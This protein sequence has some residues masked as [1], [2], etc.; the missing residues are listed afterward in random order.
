MMNCLTRLSIAT[1]TIATYALLSTAPASA[2]IALTETRQTVP[3]PTSTSVASLNQDVTCIPDSAISADNLSQTKNNGPFNIASKKVP[4]ELVDSFGGGTI[5]YPTNAG[6]CGR[7]GAIAV[8]PGYVSYESSIKWLGPR[9]AA[10][11][12]VVITMNTDSIYDRP[13]SRAKQL[14]HALDYVIS[15]NTV[16]NIV[17]PDRLGAIGWSM[18]GGGALKLASTRSNVR[19][20]MP[21]APYHDR[22]YGEVTT[23]T[24]VI[25]CEYDVIAAN[26]KYTNLFYKQAT[27]P[28]MNIEVNN[29]SHLCPSYRLNEKLLSKPSIAWMQ[30]HIN[31]DTRFDQFLCGREDYSISPRIS[32]YDYADCP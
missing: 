20:I 32:N 13:D 24:F 8:I 16:G 10:W 15:D 14:S 27:G 25:S 2:K 31:G 7:L 11:G 1:I 3:T 9:L 29:A 6:N 23:P 17:D 30:R 22:S 18:G 4:R 28:K 26:N 19:A 5:Y 12:F 21:L